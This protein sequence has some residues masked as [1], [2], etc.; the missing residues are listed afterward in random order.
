MDPRGGS[1][2][3]MSPQTL[4]QGACELLQRSKKG[5][6]V[7]PV[8]FL[9]ILALPTAG[10]LLEPPKGQRSFLVG[11][12]ISMA[13]SKPLFAEMAYSAYPKSV[14]HPYNTFLLIPV[15]AQLDPEALAGSQSQLVD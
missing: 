13:G 8:P 6:L 14:S 4:S 2:G 11:P 10:D 12:P 5:T 3:R 1:P 15:T 9:V 7:P